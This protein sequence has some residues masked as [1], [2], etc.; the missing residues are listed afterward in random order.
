MTRIRPIADERGFALLAA[1]MTMVIVAVLAGGAV[2][3]ALDTNTQAHTNVKQKQALEAAEAGLQV[4][5]YRIN[6]LLPSAGNCVGNAVSAPSAN[7]TCASSLTSLG[8]GT[9]YQYFT[10]PVLAPGATCVGSTV[11]NSAGVSNIC[12]TAI[13]TVGSVSAR[14]EIRAAA[15]SAVPLFPYPGIIGLSGIS[16]SN[17]VSISG[18]EASNEQVAASNGSTISGPLELGPQGSYSPSN[19]ASHP[20]QVTLTNPIV[21]SPVAPGNSATVNDDYR[22]SNYLNNPPSPASPYDPSSGVSFNPTTRS[23][24]M[25][26]GASLTLGGGIYNFCSFTTQN[27]ATIN[28]APGVSTEIFIDS[29]QDTGSGCP[30]GSGTFANWN[31]A[32]YVNPSNNP[33]ALQIYVYGP[34][35]G[36]NEVQ[37][38]NNGVFYGLI[39]A[40]TSTVEMS[41]NSEFYGAIAGQQVTLDNNAQFKWS[42]QA[43]TLNAS[44]QGLYYR[45]AW[46]QCTPSYST[47]APM[48]GC[49]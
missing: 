23:L 25:A 22:I 6:M 35:T 28:L 17:N 3:M 48:A 46:A 10:T 42:S 27:N 37:I 40:P 19:N 44:T 11:S 8:N 7:G 36:S 13:G 26:N 49:G 16:N 47:A 43:G 5:L 12:I 32:T 33:T 21:L 1:L 18:V 39:Y 45:T 24:S 4:A 9:S 14:S 29:P 41:N 15:F 30:A 2:T 34:D 31:N 38:R 20:S